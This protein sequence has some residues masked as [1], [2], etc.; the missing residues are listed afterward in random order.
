MDP[1]SQASALR[2]LARQHRG[3]GASQEGEGGSAAEEDY[4]RSFFAKAVRF[5]C[6]WCC[7][8]REK[9][10][11]LALVPVKPSA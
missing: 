3:D 10:R 5:L 8:S 11:S 4:Y 6:T 9:T 2:A 1:E 7:G